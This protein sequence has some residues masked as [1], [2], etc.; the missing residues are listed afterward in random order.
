MD[1]EAVES[2]EE[3]L[4]EDENRAK[5]KSPSSSKKRQSKMISSDEEEEDDDEE[6]A[7]EEM[8]GFIAVSFF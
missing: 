4:S 3:D 5:V 8:K 7:K 2:S 1:G 6:R